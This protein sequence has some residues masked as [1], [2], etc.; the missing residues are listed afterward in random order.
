MLNTND[1][2]AIE[3]IKQL[4]ARYFRYI[5]Q[6]NWSGLRAVFSDNFSGVFE[7]PHADAHYQSGDE[8]VTQMC[9]LLDKAVTVHH[10][11]MP[12]ITLLSPKE[13]TGIWA[14]MDFVKMEGLCFRGY[15]SYEEKYRRNDKAWQISHIHLKRFHIQTLS[16][17]S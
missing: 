6:K 15:G 8:M 5:D 17:E 3:E 12:E 13:A 14:M 16:V 7:G 4:K 11:H 10:G 2:V 1:L 9:A